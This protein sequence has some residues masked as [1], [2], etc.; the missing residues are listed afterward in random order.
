MKKD[1]TLI[2]LAILIAGIVPAA[3]PTI[4]RNNNTHVLLDSLDT[5]KITE[6]PVVAAKITQDDPRGHLTGRIFF[7]GPDDIEPDGYSDIL[8]VDVEV[9]ITST[10]IS[11][12]VVMAVLYD[13]TFQQRFFDP[14]NDELQFEGSYYLWGNSSFQNLAIGTHNMTVNFNCTQ[15]RA[16]KLGG[17]YA[18]THVQLANGTL[19]DYQ[20]FDEE[21]TNDPNEKPLF[22]IPQIFDIYTFDEPL[23]TGSFVMHH[24][25]LTTDYLEVNVTFQSFSHW[26]N[27]DEPYYIRLVLR[28]ET[29]VT[30]GHWEQTYWLPSNTLNEIRLTIPRGILGAF[31]FGGVMTPIIAF[32]DIAIVELNHR[33]PF[34]TCNMSY[35]ISPYGETIDVSLLAQIP[36]IDSGDSHDF[37]DLAIDDSGIFGIISQTTNDV[38]HLEVDRIEFECCQPDFD[39]W[40]ID[41]F[42]RSRGTQHPGIIHWEEGIDNVYINHYQTYVGKCPGLWLFE[43]VHNDHGQPPG[44][45]QGLTVKVDITEDTSPPSLSFTTPSDGDHF[46][47]YY[48]IPIQG[49]GTD[50]SIIL[51]Y[52]I[53][54]NQKVLYSYKPFEWYWGEPPM[55]DDFS[56]VW[57]P[58]HDLVGDIT[59]TIRAFDMTFK[60]SETTITISIDAGTI[61]SPESTINKGLTW[62]RTHQNLDGSWDY[63]SDSEYGRPGMAALGALCFIQAGLAH[64]SATVE[65][66]NYLI[67][68]FEYDQDDG[69]SIYH[70]TYE[71]AMATTTLIAY[72]A[73]RPTYDSELNSLIEDAIAWLVVTQ[74]D[75]TW[76]VDPSEPWYGGWRYGDDHQSSDLSVSQWVILA[77]STYENF[78]PHGLNT[79]DPNLWSKVDTFVRRCRGGYTDETQWIYDGGFTYTPSTEDWRDWGGGS[80]GSM[81]AAGIWGLYLSGSEPDNPDIVSALDWINNSGQ[82]VGGNPQSGRSFEYY[83]YL[84]AS[85]AFLM[86][87]RESDQWWYEKI[88]GFL[89]THMIYANPTSAYWDNTRGGEPP[90]FATVQAILS[91]QVYYGHIPMHTLEVTLE[92]ADGSAIYLWNSSMGV[93]YNYTTG[94]QE[95]S[96]GTSYSGLLPDVQ[97]VSILSPTKGEYQIEVFPAAATDGISSP[98]DMVLRARALTESGHILRYRTYV[99]DYDDPSDYPQVLRYRMVLTTISGLDIHLLPDGYKPFTHTVNFDAISAPTY[100]EL[101]EDIGV[102]VTLTNIGVGT[103]STGTVFTVAEDF[104]D[105]SEGFTN[106]AENGEKSFTFTYDTS[107]LSARARTIVIGLIGEDITPLLIRFKVQVGN[108][109]PQGDL[110]ALDSVLSGSE[111]LSWSATDPDGDDLSFDVILVRPD[112]SEVTLESNSDKFKYSF[113]TTA[114]PDGSGYR[115]IVIVSDGIDTTELRSSLFEIK[116]AAE[117]TETSPEAPDIGGIPGFELIFALIALSSILIY[118]RRRK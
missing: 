93:G 2:L 51:Q 85:K 34:D 41:G 35:A 28:N 48:G 104:S 61:P 4:A 47:Q 30:I 89:N 25:N 6:I 100:V 58:P 13:R 87:G 117:T 102:T 26:D 96:T 75:E 71:T 20:V 36:I 45:T 10:E 14:Y 73:T 55:E 8:M 65:A 22:L 94:I 3:I 67:N 91:Q 57:F 27:Q 59:M 17:P 97:Q 39:V 53:L 82:I 15:L 76:G 21:W 74:N 42:G 54:S 81:T 62:L 105:D 40:Y 38:L 118:L 92:S 19:Y 33:E 66:I 50:E 99:I 72:N 43:V 49:T 107:G 23:E 78:N 86:A 101:N 106:W 103:I 60:S 111:T 98:Q 5:D 29:G 83:W 1:K 79:Y 113:D 115:I 112:G 56:F 108:R 12:F 68:T 9:E 114:Y 69:R 18:I 80:Y 11:D 52:Q 32:E 84:S 77:L 46:L 31:D 116:N 16:M 7:K 64:E 95:S 88:T 37:G 90:V 70:S 110:D 63:E 24:T 44:T 109:A